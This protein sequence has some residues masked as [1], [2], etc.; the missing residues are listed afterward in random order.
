MPPLAILFDVDVTSGVNERLPSRLE[1]AFA[2]CS[3]TNCECTLTVR[4]LVRRRGRSVSLTVNHCLL[5]DL[6]FSNM[7]IHTN[8]NRIPCLHTF[9]RSEL[10]MRA[11]MP[12]SNGIH[13]FFTV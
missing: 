4:F 5:Q 2:E 11:R 6:Y 8:R 1:R 3:T 13:R 12:R 7:L 10:S 9:A